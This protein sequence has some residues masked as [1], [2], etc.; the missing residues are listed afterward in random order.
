MPK[1]YVESHDGSLL[2]L[3]QPE[4]RPQNEVLGLPDLL[5]PN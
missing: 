2:M 1:H 4:L 3:T 5:D